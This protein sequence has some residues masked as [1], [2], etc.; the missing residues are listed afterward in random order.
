TLRAGIAVK[1]VEGTT[2]EGA[3]I[4][5]PGRTG[6]VVNLPT[7]NTT[8][9]IPGTAIKNNLIVQGG[10]TGILFSGSPQTADGISHAVP[11]GRIVN[12]TIV[13]SPFGIQVTD[14]ASP[15]ILN[16]VIAQIKNTAINVDSTS[17]TTIVGANLYKSNGNNLVAPGGVVETGAIALGASAPL[18]VNSSKNNFYLLEGSF[19]IDSSVNTLPER[20]SLQVVTSPLGIPPSPI[21][22]PDIDLLGQLR[23][24]D[25]NTQPNGIGQN[26]FKDRGALERADFL[27]PIAT[28]ANPIDNDPAGL[29][30]NTSLNKV[31]LIGQQVTSFSFQFSDG[32]TGIDDSSVDVSKFSIQ[33]NGAPLVAGSA[34]TLSY[35][36]TNKLAKLIP[37]TGVWANGTYTIT[38]D[39]SITDL[40]NNNLQAN[41]PPITQFTIQLSDSAPSKFQNPKNRFDV[42]PHPVGQEGKITPQDLLIVIN[43]LLRGT[44]ESVNGVGGFPLGANGLIPSNATISPFPDDNY[45]DVDG[46]GSLSPRDALQ[47]INFLNNPPTT[48][49][50][51]TSLSATSLPT[52]SPGAAVS[53][54]ATVSTGATNSPTAATIAS[55]LTVAGPTATT[56]ASV[57]ATVASP[58]V[59]AQPQTSSLQASVPSVGRVAS[60][61]LV[62]TFASSSWDESTSDLDSI[63]TDL[64]ADLRRRSAVGSKNS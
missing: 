31:L 39:N 50:A 4:G 8:S 46:N 57:A 12:N 28:L 9:V 18:F 27:G 54:S 60:S 47:V 14:N 1:P 34:F 37:P 22:A 2:G 33:F 29:D 63:L 20:A 35:D 16:N 51:A 23:V 26:V 44:I 58:S 49:A 17:A 40:A 62:S 19:A 13:Q 43:D 15:T 52:A 61:V 21:Q 11:F 5:V 53:P 6:A 64:T 36:S 56:T 59:P 42:Y 30:H 55:G 24:D 48:T 7:L 3:T 32:G 38:L 25:P 45:P 10:Q 41:Q